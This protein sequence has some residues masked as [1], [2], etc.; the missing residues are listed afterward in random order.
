MLLSVVGQRDREEL[1]CLSSFR[2]NTTQEINLIAYFRDQLRARF[3]DSFCHFGS[4]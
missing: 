2:Y 4:S 1:S 3:C